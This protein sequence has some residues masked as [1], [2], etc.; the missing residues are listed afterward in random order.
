MTLVLYLP[1]KS[2]TSFS[3]ACEMLCSPPSQAVAAGG[4]HRSPQVLRARLV[5]HTA[6]QQSLRPL[7]FH[8][9]PQGPKLQ[10]ADCRRQTADSSFPC[11]FYQRGLYSLFLDCNVP[12]HHPVPQHCPSCPS[13]PPCDAC[14]WAG[15]AYYTHPSP[16]RG[17]D[18]VTTKTAYIAVTTRRGG[19]DILGRLYGQHR[20]SFPP[21]RMV[22]PSTLSAA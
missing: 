21:L 1:G 18:A 8:F 4:F 15:N 2:R 17:D 13:T 12:Q 6:G 9:H 22:T 14:H 10:T 3:V 16:S 7:F 5:Y 19:Y 11:F 20:C